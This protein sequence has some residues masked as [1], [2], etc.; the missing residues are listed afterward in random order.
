[1]PERV[2]APPPTLVTATPPERTPLIPRVPEPPILEAAVMV[3][4]PL[5]LP[6]TVEISAPT[7]PEPFPAIDTCS[8]IVA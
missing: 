1:M 5:T 4:V 7:P 2:V 8:S 3:T 6:V